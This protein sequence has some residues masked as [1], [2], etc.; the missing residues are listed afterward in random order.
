MTFP[1]G[2]TVYS[3]ANVVSSSYLVIQNKNSLVITIVSVLTY[4]AVQNRQMPEHT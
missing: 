3:I 2:A 4:N 1:S